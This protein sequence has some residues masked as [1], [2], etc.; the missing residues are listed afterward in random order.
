MPVTI[1]Y[2]GASRIA[3]ITATGEATP[4][5]FREA[6]AA[7]TTSSSFPPDVDTLWDLRALDVSRTDGRFTSVLVA[8]RGEFPSRG[9]A[10]VAIVVGSDLGFGMGR[11]FELLGRNVSTGVALFRSVEEAQAWLRSG[12]PGDAQVE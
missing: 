5:M 2:D 11:Q 6:L 1:D 10:R 4:E 7:L 9:G 3:R 8:I 12:Q